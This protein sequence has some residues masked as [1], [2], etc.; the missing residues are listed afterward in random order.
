MMLWLPF[1]YS[2][3]H[4][5]SSFF[6][7]CLFIVS[8]FS[9]ASLFTLFLCTKIIHCTEYTITYYIYF[10]LTGIFYRCCLCTLLVLVIFELQ[11]R[12]SMPFSGSWP[13][14]IWSNVCIGNFLIVKPDL[15]F[16][17]HLFRFFGLYKPKVAYKKCLKR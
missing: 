1:F 13:A 12:Y 7:L 14:V 10:D 17:V 3:I 8:L 9:S 4:F 6:S 11:S 2:F 15:A 5:W 16:T